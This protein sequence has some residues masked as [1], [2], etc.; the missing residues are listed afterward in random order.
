MSNEIISVI[1]HLCD[2]LGIAVDWTAANAM[3]TIQQLIE[4]YARYLLVNNIIW[5]TVSLMMLTGSIT[6]FVM[7]RR[8]IAQ[9]KPWAWVDLKPVHNWE[10]YY[11][12]TT[13]M[14]DSLM[15]VSVV[16][17][18]LSFVSVLIFFGALIKAATIPEIYAAQKLM[19][20]LSNM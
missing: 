9:K 13:N 12:D 14:A 11:S 8:A 5:L 20:M 1:D 17:G 4:K 7:T 6:V 18:V 15:V 2:K 3:P 16:V 19:E 10:R